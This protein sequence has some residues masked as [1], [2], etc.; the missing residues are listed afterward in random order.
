[1]RISELISEL[2]QFKE[3]HGDVPVETPTIYGRCESGAD[4]EMTSCD[5]I[6]KHKNCISDEV[7]SILIQI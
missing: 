7:V 1:M 3:K 4:K 2:E 6:E 5:L